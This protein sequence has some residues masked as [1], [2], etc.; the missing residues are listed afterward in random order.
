MPCVKNGSTVTVKYIGTLDNGRIFDSTLE[1]GPLTFTV[2]SGQVFA[3]L[4]D[5]VIGMRSGETRNIILTPDQAFGPRTAENMIKVSRQSLPA[6]REV[7][8]GQKLN[9]E[10]RGGVSRIMLVVE[11]TGESVTLDGNH[12]LAGQELTF[13][14]T[15]EQI[16]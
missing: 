7:F 9:I 4:E 3:A 13:A 16:G 1:S 11:V 12:P 10:F 15:V 8:V 14:L 2:G 5:A 6:D